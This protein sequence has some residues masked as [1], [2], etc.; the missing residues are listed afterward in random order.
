[1]KYTLV[2]RLPWRQSSV[3]EHRRDWMSSSARNNELPRHSQ[4]V[5]NAD[6]LRAADVQLKQERVAR[7]LERLNCDALLLQKPSNFSWF[8]AGGNIGRAACEAAAA[9]FVTPEAR[10][11]ITNNVDAPQLFERELFG[12][13]FQVKQREWHESH[14]T[15]VTDL[16]R[17]RR[18][19]SDCGYPGTTNAE[20]EI[21]KLRMQLTELE[22]TRLRRLS[23]VAV[24]AVEATGRTV[25]AGRTESEIA[26]EVAHR[27]MNRTVQPE[28]LR[29]CAD[30]RSERFRHWTYGSDPV[31]KFA[32]ISCVAK[33]WGLCVAVSRTVSLEPV[34]K[35][36]QDAHRKAMLMHAT[37]MFFS[38]NGAVVSDVWK[39]VQRIY[40]KFG[41]PNEWRLADQAH[42]TA[43][44]A[45]EFPITP[46]TDF[47]L[48][49]PMAVHWHPSVGPATLGDTVLVQPQ[50]VEF[51]THAREWPQLT[52]EIKGHPVQCPDILSVPDGTVVENH[53]TLFDEDEVRPVR[54]LF[55]KDT[56]PSMDSVWE[57]EID[58]S[59]F[60]S[61]VEPATTRQK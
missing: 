47:E 32:S 6:E 61:G 10:L 3:F 45:R 50:E 37:G 58:R 28:L 38:R 15:L 20:Q 23:R 27:L 39:K 26:G 25:E 17:G 14:P 29:V 5:L 57:M 24:H 33:R 59:I 40:E 54:L 8:T 22:C 16:I 7:L 2:T 11:V 51:L 4:R 36:L 34:P 35:V 41:L 31:R 56:G 13:G 30:G 48:R 21:R 60:E 12:L 1:M 9:V 42:V 46:H 53:D 43:F 19:L 49:A 52:V 44:E 18:V 55:D